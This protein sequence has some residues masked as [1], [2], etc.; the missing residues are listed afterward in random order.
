MGAGEDHAR[1]LGETISAAMNQGESSK[2]KRFQN[3][4]CRLTETQPTAQTGAGEKDSATEFFGSLQRPAPDRMTTLTFSA[5]CHFA[6][7]YIEQE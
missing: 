6:S 7:I 1:E 2:R 4:R 5:G 3:Y